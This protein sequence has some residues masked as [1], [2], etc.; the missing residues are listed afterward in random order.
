MIDPTG[1]AELLRDAQ[2]GD[3]A[4]TE[5]LLARIRPIL[6]SICAEAAPSDCSVG[7]AD[8]LQEIWLRVWQ[9]LGQV[10][11]R[12]DDRQAAAMF[13][14]WLRRVAQST[15][16]NLRDARHAQRRRPVRP[17]LRIANA[18]SATLAAGFG[19]VSNDPTPSAAARTNE[20]SERVL[21]A[22]DCIADPLTRDVIRLRFFE[23]L[24]MPQIAERLGIT[25]DMVRTRFH[26]GLRELEGDLGALL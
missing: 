22:L 4:A 24:A 1:F 14:E 12:D 11:T 20:T 13:Y 23:D 19:L 21:R 17:V 25:V 2:A 16:L 7:T 18:E 6:Q 10:R 9:K 8:C 15:L 26:A 5:H 3:T